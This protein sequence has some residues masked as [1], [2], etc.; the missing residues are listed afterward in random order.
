[1]ASGTAVGVP[2]FA[3]AARQAVARPASPREMP[4]KFGGT[5]SRANSAYLWPCPPKP[6]A[7]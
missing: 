5:R 7:T 3:P 1:M 6:D 2:S 4:N